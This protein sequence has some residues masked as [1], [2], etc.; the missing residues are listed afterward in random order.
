M[1][2]QKRLARQE[3]R[4]QKTI[5]LQYTGDPR[6]LGHWRSGLANQKLVLKTDVSG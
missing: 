6:H 2:H 4:P 5:G 1:R 3:D